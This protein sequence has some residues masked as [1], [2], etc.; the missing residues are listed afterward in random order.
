MMP[1]ISSKKWVPYLPYLDPLPSEAVPSKSSEPVPSASLPLLYNIPQVTHCALPLSVSCCVCR[2][3]L[4][5]FCV[6]CGVISCCVCCVVLL[7]PNTPIT[8][9]IQSLRSIL[10]TPQSV[11]NNHLPSASSPTTSINSLC[12][13]PPPPLPA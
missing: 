9:D 2:V 3:V 12:P 1:L 10:P 7:M 5:V 4:C 8:A 13:I 6:S 11:P